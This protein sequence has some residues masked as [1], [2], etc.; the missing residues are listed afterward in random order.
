MHPVVNYM[1]DRVED[2]MGRSRTGIF[3]RECLPPKF[4]FG[5]IRLAH[6]L[7]RSVVCAGDDSQ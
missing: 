7:F 3:R 4:K 6:G 1:V 2:A 5:S